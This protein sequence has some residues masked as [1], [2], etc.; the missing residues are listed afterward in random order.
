MKRMKGNEQKGNEG[1]G[2][3]RERNGRKREGKKWKKREK[4]ICGGRVDKRIKGITEQ[5]R[6]NRL[7]KKREE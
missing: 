1:E 3:E 4:V 7:E 2:K 6:R 5:K